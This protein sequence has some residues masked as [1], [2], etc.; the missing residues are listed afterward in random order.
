M[1]ATNT[2]RK[3]TQQTRRHSLRGK[4][5][6]RQRCKAGHGTIKTTPSIIANSI[7][8]LTLKK[9]TGL[10]VEVKVGGT[11]SRRWSEPEDYEKMYHD[12]LQ[13]VQKAVKGKTGYVSKTDP[14]AGGMT[15]SQSLYY[16]IELF[17]NEILPSDFSFNIDRLYGGEYCFTVYKEVPFNEWLHA[18]EVR[19]IL[20]SLKNDPYLLNLYKSVIAMLVSHAGINAWWDGGFYYSDS[21]FEDHILNMKDETDWDDE[22]EV[23]RYESALNTLNSYKKG[24]AFIAGKSFKKI[25]H[26][27]PEVLRASIKKSKSRNPIKK[28]LISAC[29]FL[30]KPG[31]VI[32][33]IFEEM[34][35]FNEY[36]SYLKFDQFF[37]VIW[38]MDDEVSQMEME[39]IDCDANE[40]IIPPMLNYQIGPSNSTYDFSDC[41]E[42]IR[43]PILISDLW[44][45]HD[46]ISSRIKS[47]R[48]KQNGKRQN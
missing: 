31:S 21:I 48:I 33:F 10:E 1:P 24:E 9:K 43:W 11:Y 13:A 2:K 23:E 16:V 38:D 46:K 3:T 41:I 26:Q 42:R 12:L 32:D 47:K 44:D 6:T 45:A 30:M 40:G 36:G 37:A 29:D 25:K 5:E 39:C 20:E 35:Y 22:E 34:E 28:W 27:G 15:L 4:N 7:F 19:H 17:K 18:F 14:Y 8:A